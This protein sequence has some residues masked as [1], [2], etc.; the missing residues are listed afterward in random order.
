[1]TRAV[2]KQPHIILADNTEL[3]RITVS[4]LVNRFYPE[5]TV[6]VVTNG[7]EVLMMH[8]QRPANLI[9]TDYLMPPLGGVELLQTLRSRGDVTPVI[10]T[11]ND[12]TT[13]IRVTTAPGA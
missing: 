5:A 11:A 7:I 4:Y 8:A 1:M 3:V 10:V 9:L 6:S 2:L 13:A 12:A